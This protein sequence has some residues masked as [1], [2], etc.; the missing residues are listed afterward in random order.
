[1]RF[2]FILQ[3]MGMCCVRCCY[4]VPALIRGYTSDR[5]TLLPP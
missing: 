4:Q 2:D 1:V 3:A 5:G